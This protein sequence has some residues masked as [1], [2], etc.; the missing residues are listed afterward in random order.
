MP[1]GK[2]IEKKQKRL[3]SR[4]LVQKSSLRMVEN[5]SLRIIRGDSLWSLSST[6]ILL[7]LFPTLQ[8][9][10][11]PRSRSQL[12]DERT[13]VPDYSWFSCSTVR[14]LALGTYLLWLLAIT[15]WGHLRRPVLSWATSLGRPV[16]GLFQ[17]LL[18]EFTA[19]GSSIFR[20]WCIAHV[21]SDLEEPIIPPVSV[22]DSL[23]SLHCSTRICLCLW[24]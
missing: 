2:F 10:S 4:H 7:H 8:P 22:S 19:D 13:P 1:K 11:E 5:P 21:A 24:D 16:L 12:S 14:T 20:S 9:V 15:C 18:Q 6:S 23:I 3:L 17:A